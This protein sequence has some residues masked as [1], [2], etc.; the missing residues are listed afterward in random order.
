MDL[1]D[2][3]YKRRSIREYKNQDISDENLEKIIEAALLAPTSRNRNPCEFYIIKDKQ[4]LKQLSNAKKAG[5]Q[6]LK[7]ANKAIAVFADS[8]K[9]DTWIEDSSIALTY[10]HLIAT[11]LGIGSCWIQ[12]HMREDIEGKDAEKN[13]REILDIPENFRIVGIIALGIPNQERKG[14]TTEDLDYSK[15]HLI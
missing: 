10:I 2:V 1:L 12:L 6:F 7:N 11:E 4:I 14:K 3:M 9:A 8:K 15:I 5:S 13:A